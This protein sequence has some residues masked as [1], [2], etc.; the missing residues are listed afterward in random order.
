MDF[1]RRLRHAQNHLKRSDRRLAEVIEAYGPCLIKPHDNHYAELVMSIVGQQLSTKAVSTIWSRVL[2]IFGGHTPTPEEIVA[3]D[4]E[5]LRGAGISYS[6]ISYMKDLA[7]HILDGRLDLMHIASLP[8]NE[9]IKQLT[10]VKGIGGWSA[11]MFMI[12]SLGRLDV[13][14]VGDLG[15]R[16]AAMNLY[17]LKDLPAAGQLEE[18]ARKNQW[19]P[20]QSV[21]SWYLWKSL[22]NESMR[23]KKPPAKNT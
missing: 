3:A 6:K 14:P 20:Y 1:N 2:G 17:G 9:L 4:I 11:H 23:I 5:A 22:D 19:A 10:A 12:F 18:L 7:Q 15:I 13:L 8:N 21:A 16:K